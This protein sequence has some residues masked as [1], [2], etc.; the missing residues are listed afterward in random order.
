MWTRQFRSDHPATGTK[1][2][3]R[4]LA[5]LP[6]GNWLASVGR[7]W[8]PLGIPLVLVALE[9]L[10]WLAVAK[11]WRPTEMRSRFQTGR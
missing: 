6:F 11:P 8:G 10:A 3:N 2:R 4:V 5:S 1:K 7:R 9:V